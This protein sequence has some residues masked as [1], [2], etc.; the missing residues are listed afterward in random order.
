MNYD[1]NDVRSLVTVV[2][3]A[4]FIVLMAWTLRRRRKAAFEEAAM[5]PFLDKDES[6]GASDPK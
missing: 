3:L 2:S 6:V 1:L 5:L 4:L